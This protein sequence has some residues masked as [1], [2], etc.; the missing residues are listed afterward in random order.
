MARRLPPLHLEL[1]DRAD[2][3]VALVLAGETARAELLR[4]SGRSRP[5]DVRRIELLYEFAFLRTFVAWEVF[6]ESTFL[7]YA[8]GY[9]SQTGPLT[10]VPGASLHGTLAA[11]ETAIFGAKGFALWHN[12]QTILARARKYFV[13][14]PHDTVVGSNS[15]RLDSMSSVRHWVAHGSKDARNKFDVA[16]NHLAG[17]RYPGSN[18]G[19]FLRDFVVGSSPPVRHLEV[20]SSELVGLAAQIV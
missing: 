2:E 3:A 19:R 17:R 8:C 1:K 11:A 9:E 16:T 20:L 18:A 12:T 15:A 14:A 10:L 4:Y 6:L 5:L 13:G 7:R